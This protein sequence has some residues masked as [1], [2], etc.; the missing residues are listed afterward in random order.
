M[1]CYLSHTITESMP[2]Y[3]RNANF[4]LVP[5]KNI[6]QGDFC[7]TWRFCLENHWG[8]HVDCPAHF[9][10]N[11][12]KVAEYPPEFWLFKKPRIIQIEANPGQIITWA[13]FSS[14]LDPE[15][16]FCFFNRGGGNSGERKF[17]VN[18]IPACIRIWL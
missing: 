6:V 13:D 11:S 18:T 2:I 5:V 7:N 17:I 16:T 4:D 10:A 12:K 9:F 1:I 14:D 15:P 3:G 8:T